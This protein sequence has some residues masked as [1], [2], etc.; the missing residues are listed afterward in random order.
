MVI[1]GKGGTDAELIY[2]TADLLY[3]SLVLL[4]AVIFRSMLSGLN[5]NAALAPP[6]S[7]K[8]RP[9]RNSKTGVSCKTS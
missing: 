8:R 3:H 6:V 5:C 1:A 7:L 9:A 2:E 4:A